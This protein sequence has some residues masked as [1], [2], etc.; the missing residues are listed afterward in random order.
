MHHRTVATGF[1]GSV[2]TQYVNTMNNR[3]PV[4]F[5]GAVGVVLATQSIKCF[6]SVEA[7][8]G[9]GIGDGTKER[10]IAAL[11]LGASR[12]RTYCEDN[13]APGPLLEHAI[14]SGAFTMDTSSKLWWCIL[15][16][17]SI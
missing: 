8:R 2:E 4:P 13:L 9:N 6:S 15:M 1:S 14:P 17:K 7:W 5:V 16:M 10:L 12:H 3:H 11:S